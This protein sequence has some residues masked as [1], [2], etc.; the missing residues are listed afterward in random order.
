LNPKS[1]QFAPINQIMNNKNC[2]DFLR[3]FFA[4]NILLAHLCELSQSK[5]LG[6]LSCFSNSSIA[7]KGFFVISGFLVAKSYVNTPSLKEYFIK[8]AKRILPAYIIVLLISTICLSLFSKFSFSTYFSNTSIYQYLGWNAL[9]LN[10]MH[11]CLPGLFENNLIC[12]VNGALWTLKVE[13][14]FYIVLPLIF[15]AIHQ[16]KKPLLILVS[17]YLFSILYWFVM[18]FYFNQPLLAKQLPGYLA[19]FATGIFIFLNFNYVLQHK[20][21]LFFLSVV[22]L[23]ISI[24]INIQ[25]DLLFPA[26]F[27]SI[28][29]I[30]A[31]SLSFLN[32]FGKYGDFTY[33][34]YIYH[35]PI[36]QLFRQYNLFEKYNPI[37]M[38]VAVILITMFF[39]VFS[40][41]FI[42]KRFLDRYKNKDSQQDLIIC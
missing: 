8:R 22:L 17:L 34:L 39:A 13:E 37:I 2:F 15:Y 18:D 28:V 7:V 3:F 4:V 26:A 5:S 12:A 16:L 21:K 11:P 32:N 9:F 25:I 38:S 33:G 40:W 24:F 29:I 42:E 31:Y 19:Y 6:F 10:F 1:F 23:G 36:I 30:A 41:F 27:G 20:N 35:F 14:G